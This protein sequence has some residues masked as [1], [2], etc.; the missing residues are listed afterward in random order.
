[1]QGVNVGEEYRDP[2]EELVAVQAAQRVMRS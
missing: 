1:V 2:A